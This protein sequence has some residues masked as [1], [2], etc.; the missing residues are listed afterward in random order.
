MDQRELLLERLKSRLSKA[1]LA[2]S[3]GVEACAVE[4]ADRFGTDREKASTAGLIH[5]CAKELTHRQAEEL[6]N[7]LG[8]FGDE[9]MK[10]E[11]KLWHAPLGAYIA[12]RDYG[13]TDPEVLGA[14]ACHTTGKPGMTAL[15]KIIYLADFVEPRRDFYGVEELRACA[16]RDL[17]EALIM[18]LEATIRYL[19]N[20]GRTIHPH[21]ILARNETIAK[22]MVK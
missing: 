2:H 5:D 18:A 21:T 16:R 11:P 10:A 7:R 9:W 12:G 6:G 19:L 8:I 20:H 15:E 22:K 4:M 1:R 14:I 13:V 3:L 17:D